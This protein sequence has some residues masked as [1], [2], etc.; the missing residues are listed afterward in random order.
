VK[1]AALY[2]RVSTGDQKPENQLTALRAFAGARGWAVTEFVDHGVSGA[3]DRRPQLD[4]MLVDARRRKFDV[5]AIVKLDRLARS[6]R[7]LVTL[8]AELEAL[9]VDLVVLDQA[10]DTTTPSGRLLFHMLAA[11]AEFERDLIRD[12]VLAGLRRAR[13]HGQRLGRPRLHHVD[14]DEASAL[15]AEGLSYGAIAKRLGGY[16]AT[17]RRLLRAKA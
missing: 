14:V 10:I 4:A 1:R 17:I 15:R 3:K 12:R 13:A 2:A 8:A 16:G 11:V 7:H 9:G 6:T 5:V